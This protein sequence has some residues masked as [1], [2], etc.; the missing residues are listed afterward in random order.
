M[1]TVP[2]TTAGD[3]RTAPVPLPVRLVVVAAA[4]ALGVII[5]LP[6]TA[7][8]TVVTLAGVGLL[9]VGV[10]SFIDAIGEPDGTRRGAWWSGALAGAALI[11]VGLVVLLWKAAA[12]STLVLLAAGA[13]ILH[14][15]HAIVSAV[16]GTS[17]HRVAGFLGGAAGVALGLFLLLWPLLTIDLFRVVIGAWLVFVGLRALVE[18]LLRRRRERH[19]RRERAGASPTGRRLLDWG[20]TLLAAVALVVAVVLAVGSLKIFHPNQ[21]PAPDDFYAAPADLPDEPGVLLRAEPF[22]GVAPDGAESWKILYTTTMPDGSPTVASGTVLAPADRDGGE[23]AVLSVAHGTTG[24]VPHCAPSL[25][26]T[27]FADGAESALYEMVTDHGWAGVITDYVGLGTAGVHPYLVG[28]VEARN[29]LDATRAARQLDGVNLGGGTVVWGHSQGGHAALWTGQIAESYAP[30]LDVRAIAAMA[31]AT[32]LYS[33]AEMS[34]SQIGGKTVSAYIA[35]AWDGFYPKMNLSAQLTPG[36]A[37]GVGEIA[38]L[39]FNQHDALAA[40]AH[41]SQLP[42]QVFP[43]SLLGDGE[44]GDML[45]ANTPTGPFPAPVLVAQGLSDPLVK[46]GMQDGW[47]RD[48]CDAGEEIDYRTFEGRDHMGV[49]AADSP[50]MPQLVEWTLGQWAGEPPTPNCGGPAN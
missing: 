5:V 46:P 22:P 7:I 19:G 31:P 29:V 38:D 42:E 1:P 9:T 15:L 8:T 6:Q 2:S 35:E 33:L 32:D 28:E 12:V 27:P 16:R 4:I 3:A 44:L 50:L 47:V 24:I 34:K 20:R 48:R 49:V 43:D 21:R 14:G 23:L 10:L 25:S 41:G 45:R 36:T 30:D 13:V 37:R 26:A 40:I 17:D 39:C 18:P 11:A